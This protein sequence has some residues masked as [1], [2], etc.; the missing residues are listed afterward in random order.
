M[1]S[2]AKRLRHHPRFVLAFV[3]LSAV[4]NV[5]LAQEDP[6]IVAELLIT[7]DMEVLGF[8]I[9]AIGS[10]FVNNQG[11]TIPGVGN[12]NPSNALDQGTVTDD[13]E[14]TYWES[15]TLPSFPS[16]PIVFD[17][18]T[19]QRQSSGRSLFCVPPSI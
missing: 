2:L 15:D 10:N 11:D 7:S 8:P 19:L 3:A 9:T 1:I 13:F 6:A 14:V 16:L 17:G 5:A 12:D 18:V 4:G